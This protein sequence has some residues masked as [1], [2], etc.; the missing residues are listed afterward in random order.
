VDA[1]DIGLGRQ[2]NEK[3]NGAPPIEKTESGRAIDSPA[4]NRACSE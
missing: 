1:L 2:A 3:I 4:A